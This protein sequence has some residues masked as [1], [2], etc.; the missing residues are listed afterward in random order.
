[1]DTGHINL[2]E[3]IGRDTKLKKAASTNGGEWAGPCPFCG[4]R[5]RFRVW[6]QPA[7]GKPRFWCRQCECSGDA[8]D[9]V[10][11]RDSVSF[12]AACE[13][14]N[15]Q[16]E[17][18]RLSVCRIQTPRH[19]PA[20]RRRDYIAL[21][22]PQ[23][24]QAAQAFCAQSWENLWRKPDGQPSAGLAYLRE[25]GFKDGPLGAFEVGYNPTPCK[26][27]WGET[28]I[29]LPVGIVI[30]HEYQERIWAINVRRMDKKPRN[31]FGQRAAPT[32]CTFVRPSR[33]RQP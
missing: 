18:E 22:C 10:M 28:T 21:S 4:G 2:L 5:D 15:L 30:P 6:P 32:A 14:L 25:R 1:M 3:I 29:Y 23:W 26:T 19:A 20:L 11:H 16:P 24:Q 31:T 27:L 7:D 12:R 13:K 17:P 9:Y 8:I 33:N